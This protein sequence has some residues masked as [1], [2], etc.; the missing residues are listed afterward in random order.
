MTHDLPQFRK[1]PP[2][3]A[4]EIAE[5]ALTRPG[6][7]ITRLQALLPYEDGHFRALFRAN[8]FG[9]TAP[10]KSQWNS[11]KKRFKRHHP[12]VFVFKET[13]ETDADG[14]RLLYIDFGFFA[15]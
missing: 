13:G 10:S 8:Y 12:G 4:R 2:E 1:V 6:E 15:Q 5:A 9:E 3:Y 14:E 11:L 7:D